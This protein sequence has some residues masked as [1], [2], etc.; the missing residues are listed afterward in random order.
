MRHD[1]DRKFNS[2]QQ[3]KLLSIIY[4][5]KYIVIYLEMIAKKIDY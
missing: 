2:K 4:I 3:K 5:K 1:L